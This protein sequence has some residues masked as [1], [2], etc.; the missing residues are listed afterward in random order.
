MTYCSVIHLRANCSIGEFDKRSA[1]RRKSLEAFFSLEK[2]MRMTTLSR[3]VT[4]GLHV[5]GVWPYVPSTILFRFYWTVMLGMI[6]IFQYWYLITNV[7]TDD[8]SQFMDGVSC[9][10]ATSL[11]YIKLV[12]LWFNQRIFFDLLQLMIT[13]WHT[14]NS[15]H[16]SL[17]ML[18]NTANLARRVSMWIIGMQ[19]AS[20]TF[21]GIGVLAGNVSDPARME[22]YARELILKMA[23]PFNISTE[24][25]YLTIQ[26]IQFYHLLFIGYGM[27]LVNS[28][29]VTLILHVS[30]QID[31]LCEWLTNAFSRKITHSSEEILMRSM[32]RKHQ[33]IILFAENVDN[34]YTYIALMMLLSDTLIICCLGFIIVTSLNAPDAATILV[35]SGLFYIT[36]NLEAFIYCFAGEY[37]SAKSKMIGHAAYHSVWY[38]CSN[39]ESRIILFIILRSQKT[40]TIT[41]GRMMDLSL[42]RF[43]SVVK[44][45]ASYM[46]VL[47][48]RMTTLSRG[49]TLGLHVFGVWPYVPST[50]L[51]RFYW[52]VMLSIIQVFQYWYLITNVHTDDFSQFMDGV[53]CVLA[54]SLLYIKLIILWVNQRIFFDILQMMTTDW[55]DYNSNYHSS[56]VLTNTANL[57]HRTS[58]WI[59]GMQ[60]ASVTFYSAGVLAANVANPERIEPHSRELILKM[61]LPFNISTESLYFTIQSVQF[62][63]LLVLGYGMTIVNSFLVTLILHVGGQID[64]LCDWLTNVFSRNITHSSKEITMRSIIRKHQQIILFAKKI[65]NLYMYIALTMLL[66]DTLIICCVGFIIVTSLDA[67][68]AATILVKSGLF[69]ITIN[70]EAFIYCFAGEYLRAKSKMIG[71]AAYDSVWYDC[72]T[73]ESRNILFVI[74]R[75][76]KTLTI[77]SGR[78]MDLSLE[79]F[80]SVIKASASYISVLLAMY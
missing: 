51:F 10:L 25:L 78:M 39:T 71:H 6:Q 34:L 21:Y 66:S 60:V 50:I 43:T 30:G 20:V 7:H 1:R 12:I 74:V 4:F 36:I 46:S 70:L 17:L 61:A 13:D 48:M 72:P 19:M 65:E 68:D 9:V 22:P 32:I 55:R 26:S 44:A 29:L 23:F 52:V 41:S 69:Y 58:T 42:E 57:A 49:V 16:Q 64:I 14:Y 47:L 27:A 75:S 45:S 77:T 59:I 54:C 24:P 79:R 38:N 8:F 80:T 56:R 62:Y 15:N 11:L 33:Q 63:H 76:Q 28:F 18:T 67:P 2:K 3:A 73:T 37:L 35:K 40:L 53:S 31:I 5:F